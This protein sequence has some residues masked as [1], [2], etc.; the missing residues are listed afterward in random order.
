M[1]Y[2]KI[3]LRAKKCAFE[4]QKQVTRL[5]AIKRKTDRDKEIVFAARSKIESFL[6]IRYTM[7][8]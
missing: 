1:K 5:Q 7:Y 2:A 8:K 3:I 4:T 6:E